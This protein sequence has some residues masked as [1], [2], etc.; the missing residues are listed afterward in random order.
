MK[1]LNLLII[2]I[3]LVSM[4]AGT[5]M[6]IEIDTLDKVSV[7][8]P[9]S[10]VHSLLGTPDE[11]IK[12]GNGLTADIYKV[13]KA[14]P[15]IGAGCIYQDNRQ[16]AGQAF[17]FQ[18]L[19]NKEAAERLVKHGFSVT[20]ETEGAYRLIGKDDDSGLPLVAQI[21]L[22][23]GMTVIMTFEKGFYDRWGK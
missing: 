9:Q 16:L 18:G 4:F 20:E 15:L 7:L 8:M 5:A 14:E 11:V 22:N 17:I 23:N 21:A 10:K 12:L 6:A 3:L 1:L 19:V 2:G 13:T